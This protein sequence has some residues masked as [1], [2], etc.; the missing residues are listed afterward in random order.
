MWSGLMQRRCLDLNLGYAY[1]F[2]NATSMCTTDS[3]C[4]LATSINPYPGGATFVCEKVNEFP[5]NGIGSFDV[6]YNA[7]IV[8]FIIVTQEGWTDY[9]NFVTN[10]FKDSTYVNTII[11]FLYFHILIFVGG[12]YLLN[13]FL[14]VVWSQ[15]SEIQ[16]LNL[17]KGVE[18]KGSLAELIL[19]KEEKDRQKILSMREKKLTEEQKIEKKREKFTFIEKDPSKIPIHYRTISDL[20]YINSLTA[21][22]T[23]NL[24]QRIELEAKRAEMEYDEEVNKIRTNLGEIEILT[25]DINVKNLTD[26]SK[27]LDAIEHVTEAEDDAKFDKKF[28]LYKKKTIVQKPYYLESIINLSIKETHLDWEK[29]V[30]EEDEKDIKQTIKFDISNENIIEEENSEIE[31]I[32]NS[33]NITKSVE[34]NENDLNSIIDKLD[35]PKINP[36]IININNFEK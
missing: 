27:N 24:K 2:S 31:N 17:D 3:D 34:Y 9:Y 15:F 28:G 8:V 32:D 26:R 5:F 23:Y 7:L 13:L 6:I 20:N 25:P 12:Y 16:R 21:K 33:S 36:S 11:I 1:S 19:Q 14:A 10:T 35:K 30:K 4:Y 29:F 22:E 18:N